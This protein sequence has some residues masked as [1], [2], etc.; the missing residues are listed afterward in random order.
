MAYLQ[1]VLK[2]VWY[3]TSLEASTCKQDIVTQ[4]TQWY[5]HICPPLL[6]RKHLSQQIV[7]LQPTS[8]LLCLQPLREK[9]M[10]E[11][12][13][14]NQRRRMEE[15]ILNS[16]LFAAH[17]SFSLSFSNSVLT[18]IQRAPEGS[19]ILVLTVW[20][21]DLNLDGCCGYVCFCSSGK[22]SKTLSSCGT[23]S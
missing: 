11:E 13:N 19:I 3:F 12:Q 5:N 4:D 15:P 14:E 22:E 10:T 7:S 1:C 2:S 6:V 16:E 23:Q 8:V 17:I 9:A 20:V 18:P 21:Q